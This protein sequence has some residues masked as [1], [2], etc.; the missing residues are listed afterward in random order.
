LKPYEAIIILNS[1]LTEE[2]VD[3]AVKKFEKKIKDNGGTDISVTKWGNK[4]FAT[5]FTSV[6][7]ASEGHYVLIN[8]NGEGKTPN[9]LRDF[10]NVSE[11]VIRYSVIASKNTDKEVTE[12]KVE[13][14]PSMIDQSVEAGK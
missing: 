11:E 8:F 1:N 7:N 6:K 2:N 4:K 12:E 14:E 9:V 5:K 13:I 3:S 10:L